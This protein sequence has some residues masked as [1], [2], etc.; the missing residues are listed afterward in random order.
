MTNSIPIYVINLK[1]NPERRLH[2]KRQLDVFGL[3]YQFI[4]VDDIDKYELESKSGRT[5][6]AQSL[7]IDALVLENKYNAILG[8]PKARYRDT[9]YERHKNQHLGALATTLSHIKIY[10]LMVENNIA[11]ACIL[12]DDATLLPTFPKILNTATK[13][14][15]DILLLASQ[16][17]QF[18]NPLIW[19]TH[20]YDRLKRIYIFNKLLTSLNRCLFVYK[21]IEN[22][23]SEQQKS[24]IT[25]ILE[26][27]GFDPSLY[28]KQAKIFTK[29]L[30]EYDT[31]CDGIIA[32]ANRRLFLM[33]L[34]HYLAY[35]ELCIYIKIYTQIRLGALPEKSSLKRISD[36]HYI[37]EPR[38]LPLSATGYLVKQSAAMKWKRRALTA[39]RLVIDQ[40]PW[41]LYK[42]Q[43]VKLRLVTPPCATATYHYL[44]H[45]VRRR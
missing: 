26:E 24:R 11:A 6:V 37:A 20:Q 9:E 19:G 33:K 8:N 10:D 2:I 44:I 5:R 31:K 29:I 40:I 27:Y 3:E 25:S 17:S 38:N 18:K 42:H 45:S 28:T 23:D 7:G 35:K 15:W 30:Q 36:D 16:P 1:R 14:E 32:P 41:Q 43:Q 12:E 39:D 13:L 22:Y 34:T 4:D 21:R